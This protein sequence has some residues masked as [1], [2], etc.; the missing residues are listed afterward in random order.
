MVKPTIYLDYNATTPVDERVFAK[1]APYFTKK[2]GNAASRDHAFGWDAQEAVEDARYQVA[3][4]INARP[5]EIIFTS[6]ATESINLAIKGVAQRYREKGNHIITSAVEHPAVLDT[7]K[8]LQQEG[9]AVTYL[10]VDGEG[11]IDLQQLEAGITPQTILIAIMAANN[12]IGTVYPIAEIGQIARKHHVLFCS[13][14]TQAAGKIPVDVEQAQ[15]DLAAFS[16]HKL[17]GPK[18]V[19]ALYVRGS[20]P[21]VELAPQ[22]HGGGQERGMRSGT[23]NVP[24]IVGF[25]EA[26]RLAKAEMA[27]EIKRITELRDHLESAILSR[28][29]NVQ[30][31]GNP[32]SRLPNTTNL[33]FDR[34]ESKDL[35]RAMQNVAVSAGA[36]CS[37][38]HAGPS[39]VLKALG[40]GDGRAYS[41][42]R[43]SLGRFTTAIEI[44]HALTTLEEAVNSLRRKPE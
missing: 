10:A 11:N 38:A 7:C 14:I 25:G 31:N 42:M 35:I 40:I 12:E 6:G 44:G 26:C 23:L 37:G 21:K 27:E 33:A 13:D 41:S 32:K 36:A 34:I 30:V 28:I 2:F 1:M 19:G 9:F 24:G 17:Y 22:M 18:G 5:T 4:L 8:H 3:E 43:F 15:I 29:P 20:N 16:S 39:H